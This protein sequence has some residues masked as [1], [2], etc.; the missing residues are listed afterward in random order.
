M[1]QHKQVDGTRRKLVAGAA[2]SV[3]AIALAVAAPNAAASELPK[4]IVPAVSVTIRAVG[5]VGAYKNIEITAGSFTLIQGP[6]GTKSGKLTVTATAPL[7]YTVSLPQNLGAWSYVETST[8]P[9]KYTITHEGFEIDAS[10]SSSVQFPGIVF[11]GTGA[12]TANAGKVK[13]AWDHGTVSSLAP[14]DD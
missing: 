6:V 10:G 14:D 4:P 5:A 7:G 1:N 2:W 8:S 3:P 13:T 9:F 12:T 11:V